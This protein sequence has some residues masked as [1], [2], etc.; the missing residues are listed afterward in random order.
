MNIEQAVYLSRRTGQRVE[1]SFDGTFEEAQNEVRRFNTKR[2]CIDWKSYLGRTRMEACCFDPR[3]STAENDF[4][5]V[6]NDLK[7]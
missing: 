4:L 5:I 1:C 2:Y 3:I 7:G 6:V